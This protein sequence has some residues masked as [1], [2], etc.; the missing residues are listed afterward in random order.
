MT[1]EDKDLVLKDMCSRVPYGLRSWIK[2][3]E[4]KPDYF[5]KSHNILFSVN[6]TTLTTIGG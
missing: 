3:Y 5:I 4:R 1:Q 6:Y 2:I